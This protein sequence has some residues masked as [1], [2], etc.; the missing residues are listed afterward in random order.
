MCSVQICMPRP[1]R[2][3]PVKRLFNAFENDAE[4]EKDPFEIILSVRITALVTSFFE[5]MDDL[6]PPI[7]IESTFKALQGAI[8]HPMASLPSVQCKK[9]IQPPSMSLVPIFPGPS[10]LYSEPLRPW[11]PT[12]PFSYFSVQGPIVF[13]P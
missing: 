12:F 1:I 2:N 9:V 8:V 6:P 11:F 5:V 3:M 13:I 10:S 4:S 7:Q